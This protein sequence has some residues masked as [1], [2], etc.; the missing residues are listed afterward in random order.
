MH[1]S[2]TLDAIR[3][4]LARDTMGTG[5]DA[6]SPD[7]PGLTG[8][9]EVIPEAVAALLL[10][11]QGSLPLSRATTDALH[12]VGGAAAVEAWDALVR[13]SRCLALRDAGLGAG[14]ALQDLIDVGLSVRASC[15]WAALRVDP[16]DAV[17]LERLGMDAAAYAA[18]AAAYAQ[19]FDDGE[20]M[21]RYGDPAAEEWA[22]AQVPMS[23]V[24]RYLDHDVLF[25]EA[26]GGWEPLIASSA[27]PDDR[28][29]LYLTLGMSVDEASEHERSAAQGVDIDAAMQ[30]LMALRQSPPSSSDDPPF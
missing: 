8:W 22:L 24:Y 10:E 18:Y 3:I 19:Y 25:D 11:V 4:D 20:W 30:L 29:D 13:G 16:R 15:A 1:S 14:R 23:R 17:A 6:T 28:L 7:W 27:M 5:Y 2:F 21:V 26:V 12:A 9:S